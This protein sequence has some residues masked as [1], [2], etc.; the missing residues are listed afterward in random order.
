MEVYAVLQVK[1]YCLEM[2]DYHHQIALNHLGL[3][4]VSEERKSSLKE[5]SELLMIRQ[6]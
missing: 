4:Q 6:N 5:F 3:L 2:M 1:K